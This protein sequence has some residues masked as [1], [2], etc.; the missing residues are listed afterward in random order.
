MH[1]KMSKKRDKKYHPKISKNRPWYRTLTPMTDNERD[2]L[3]FD[4][5]F[6]LSAIENGTF[7]DDH[8]A[9]VGGAIKLAFEFV[10]RINEREAA[11]ECL[12]RGEAAFWRAVKRWERGNTQDASDLRTIREA[13]D[14]ADS[15]IR[16]MERHEILAGCKR[17]IKRDIQKR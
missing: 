3:S 6:S 5:Y 14:I 1:G 17:A 9:A 15:I 10:D 7:T 8:L 12:E 13:V 4:Y 2:N 16:L 11:I